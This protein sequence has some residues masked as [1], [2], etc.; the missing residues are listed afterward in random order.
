MTDTSELA[1]GTRAGLTD[2]AWTDLLRR[3]ND[4]SVTKHFEAYVDIDWDSDELRLDPDDPRWELPADEPLA[5]TGWYKALPSAARA[6]LGCNYA[7]YRM[8]AGLEFESIL[9]RGLLEFA[10]R[11]PNGS[12]EF[13]YAYHEVIEEAQHALMFQEFVNRSGFDVEGLNRID[14]IGARLVLGFARWFPELFFIF[15]LG[16]EDPIDHVQREHLRRGDRHPLDER[17]MRIHVTEEARHL[18]FARHYLKRRVPQLSR[19]RRAALAIGA[20]VVLA[21]M[22]EIMLKPSRQLIRDHHIPT[23]VIDEAY[24]RNP[25]H[26]QRTVVALGKVRGL[27]EELGLM[28]RRPARLW[29]AL[30]LT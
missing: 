8:K 17:I 26:R 25:E 5:A 30:K 3:L 11:L 9:K 15:V 28:G 7:A 1:A 14:R 22:S 16:G 2:E 21:A 19:R 6:R 23:E 18:S 12:P 27:C 10:S 13:R 29:R 4:Q 24:R 20:P